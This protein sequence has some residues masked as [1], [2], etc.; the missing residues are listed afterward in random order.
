MWRGPPPGRRPLQLPLGPAALGAGDLSVGHR[1]TVGHRRWPG[2]LAPRRLD[3]RDLGHHGSGQGAQ[4]KLPGTVVRQGR[5]YPD[6][7]TPRGSTPVARGGRQSQTFHFS[8]T[9]AGP[10]QPPPR[11][12][13]PLRSLRSRRQPARVAR[14]PRGACGSRRRQ[15]PGWASLAPA[16]PARLLPA[17]PARAPP[18]PSGAGHPSRALRS[19]RH[20]GNAVLRS[21]QPSPRGALGWARRLLARDRGFLD[22]PQG[23]LDLRPATL[24]P[25]RVRLGPG[26]ERSSLRFDPWLVTMRIPAP[27]QAL[28][29]A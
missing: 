20:A 27:R 11:V 21:A 7:P 5:R 19:H 10:A 13:H 14:S 8:S 3:D 26:Q 22:P 4:L 25:D 15:G 28:T 12:G 16:W 9:Q 1:A 17:P 29:R 23:A 18:G 24:D 2:P 6:R